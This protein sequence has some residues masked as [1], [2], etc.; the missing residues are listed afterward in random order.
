MGGA[1]AG[2]P[3]REQVRGSNTTVSEHAPTVGCPINY[4][5]KAWVSNLGSTQMVEALK[6]KVMKDLRDI[7]LA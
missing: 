5:S 1:R 6:I 3:A 4:Y 7:Q 2:N